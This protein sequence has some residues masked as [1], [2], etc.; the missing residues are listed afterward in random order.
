M[1]H[2]SKGYTTLGNRPPR[3]D[4][5]G[6]VWSLARS[7]IGIKII[8]CP[9]HPEALEFQRDDSGSSPAGSWSAACFTG[10]YLPA[11]LGISPITKVCLV[12]P[13]SCLVLL[14]TLA[15]KL[16][17]FFFLFIGYLESKAVVVIE[18]CGWSGALLG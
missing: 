16:N 10:L 9:K 15:V 2:S 6:N 1:Q 12:V 5:L 11:G 13:I 17:C 4:V 18:M 7:D 3:T 8:R 14:C